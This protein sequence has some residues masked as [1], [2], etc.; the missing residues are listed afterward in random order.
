MKWFDRLPPAVVLGVLILWVCLGPL[1]I[2]DSGFDWVLGDWFRRGIFLTVFFLHSGLRG[3]LRESFKRGPRGIE[4]KHAAVALLVVFA[5]DWG[6]RFSYWKLGFAETFLLPPPGQYEDI[7]IKSVDLT[8]GLLLVA[9]TEEL[10]YRVGL[11]Q[12]LEKRNVPGWGIYAIGTFVFAFAHWP[13]SNLTIVGIVF[14]TPIYIWL[15]MRHRS[16]WCVLILH[17][18]YNVLV[19]SGALAAAWY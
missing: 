16:I 15:Y 12:E 5:M 11:I 13:T 1:A 8:L 17:Y 3:L 4:I 14:D 9:V 7:W 10:I 19:F 18:S 6:V 2:G